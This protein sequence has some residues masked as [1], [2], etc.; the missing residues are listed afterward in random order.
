MN[1]ITDERGIA[2]GFV[3]IALALVLTALL[4]HTFS[5][6]IDPL[7]DYVNEGVADGDVSTDTT[8]NLSILLKLFGTGIP[9]FTIIT[10][11]EYGII[12]A[13]ESKYEQR[14]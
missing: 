10:L 1:L 7:V 8:D 4:F 3:V 2:Y 12:R 9:L 11:F 5:L 6:V 14:Y 13:I